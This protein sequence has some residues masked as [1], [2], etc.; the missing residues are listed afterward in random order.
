MHVRVWHRWR[1]TRSQR[2]VYG[3]ILTTLEETYMFSSPRKGRPHC[4]LSR[5]NPETRNRRPNRNS[6]DN[7]FDSANAFSEAR[8]PKQTGKSSNQRRLNKNQTGRKI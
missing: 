6:K 2:E 3:G 4:L 1:M 7:A 5:G 8:T